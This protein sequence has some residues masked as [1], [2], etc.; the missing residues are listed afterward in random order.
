[1]GGTRLGISYLRRRQRLQDSCRFSRRRLASGLGLLDMLEGAGAS[2]RGR[3]MGTSLAAPTWRGGPVKA[4][5]R[6]PLLVVG[7][8]FVPSFIDDSRVILFVTIRG[9]WRGDLVVMRAG[10]WPV[11][12]GADMCRS[13][14]DIGPP[15]PGSGALNSGHLP[16]RLTDKMEIGIDSHQDSLGNVAGWVFWLAEIIERNGVECSIENRFGLWTASIT[17]IKTRSECR[18]QL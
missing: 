5:T 15:K 7:K 9:P 18:L 17:V 12:G 6:A 10:I 2:G 14:A 16:A 1:M 8:P 13:S 11:S 4:E 3:G